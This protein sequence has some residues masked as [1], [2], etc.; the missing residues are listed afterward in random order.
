MNL[1]HEIK[2]THALR[3]ILDYDKQI[4]NLKKQVAKLEEEKLES[5]ETAVKWMAE[6]KRLERAYQKI[7]TD[8]VKFKERVEELDIL[9]EFS[10]F[11]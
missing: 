3:V 4:K 2:D 6:A 7:V 11:F 5:A 1:I 8:F 10:H 9:D